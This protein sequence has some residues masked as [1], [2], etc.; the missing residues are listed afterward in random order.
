[1]TLTPEQLAEIDKRMGEAIKTA[2]T[3]DAFKGALS[4]ALAPAIEGATKPLAEKLATLEA[5]AKKP[6]TPPGKKEGE[7]KP[8]DLS[9]EAQQRFAAM[10]AKLADAENKAKAAERAALEDRAHGAVRDALAKA[11][12][13]ADRIPLALAFVKSEGLIKFADDG[14]FGFDKVDQ[15]GGKVKQDPAAWAGEFVKT[16]TG[17]QLLPAAPTQGAGSQG[18]TTAPPTINGTTIDWDALARSPVATDVLSL[19]D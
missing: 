1:V 14:T 9:P 7:G 8:G 6:E 17:K 12:V 4:A 16:D 2:F 3:G 18:R 13:P 11:G 15:W 5:G 19:T 10:E